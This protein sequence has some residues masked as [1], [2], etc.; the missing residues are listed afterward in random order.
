MERPKW[1][2]HSPSERVANVPV[3]F[4]LN[5][6]PFHSDGSMDEGATAWGYL[7]VRESARAPWRIFDQGTM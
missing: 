6:R 7:L 2:G 3:T 1:S 5:W 4:D